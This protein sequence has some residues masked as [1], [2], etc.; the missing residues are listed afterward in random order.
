MKP[1]VLT[2]LV[3]LALG[4][5]LFAADATPGHKT[6]APLAEN[7]PT[8]PAPDMGPQTDG[9]FAKVILDSDQLVDGFMTDSVKD[10]MELAIAPDGHV[11]YAE[12]NGRVKVWDPTTKK[13]SVALELKVF[14]TGNDPAKKLEEG[15]LGITLDPKFAQNGWVYLYHAP[16]EGT[17]N[18]LS[19]FTYK[20]GTLDPASEKVLLKVV[21]QRQECCHAGGSLTFDK[22]GN[23]YLS[24]GDNTNPF[25]DKTQEPER[26]G[27]GPIDER[28]DRSPWDAQKSASNAND[29]RGKVLRIKPTP[30]GDYTIPKGNLFPLGTAGTRPEIFVMGCRNPF[31]ISV[32][33]KTG[34]LYW[35]DVGPDAKLPD[36]RFGAAGFDEVNQA[37]TAGFFGWPY[38]VGDNKAYTQFDYTTQTNGPLFDPLKPVNNSPNNTGIK[39]LPPSQPSWIAYAYSP[40]TRFPAVN[41]GGGRTAMAGPVYYYDEKNPN[42]HKLPKEFDHTLFIYEWS[43]N[44]II[45]VHLDEKD[46]IAKDAT[47]RLRM[48]PFCEKMTFKRPMD[49]EIGPD[50]CLY[51][52]EWGSV[53][54]GNYDTQIERLE[55]RAEAK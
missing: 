42:P 54:Y 46:Q 51:V 20:N 32:D 13:M 21:T 25:H 53:W 55:Y 7:R 49:L 23:L 22:Q 33:P 9:S 52:I 2:S 50:G 39:Q 31:R 37:R 36:P 15:L 30:Q 38:F 24:T 35:G 47:G 16:L 26:S 17:E 43:R 14:T 29:L 8:A 5:S 27:Y 3:T 45:A 1:F 11:F 6:D 48:D 18:H 10:P 19:R 41:K 4:Q 34:Y 28:P 12:R 44:W 40:S